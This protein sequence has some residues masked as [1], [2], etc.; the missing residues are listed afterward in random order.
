M[1]KQARRAGPIF[2]S[3]A[4]SRATI[5]DC[6]M[7]SLSTNPRKS[8]WYTVRSGSW[9]VHR[10]VSRS[11]SLVLPPVLET[12]ERAKDTMVE[13]AWEMPLDSLFSVVKKKKRDKTN[14]DASQSVEY[15]FRLTALKVMPAVVLQKRS[16]CIL[17]LPEGC[18]FRTTVSLEHCYIVNNNII[19]E[20][21]AP[22]K[23]RKPDGDSLRWGVDK[24]PGPKK[25]V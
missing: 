6:S 15:S 16:I 5:I 4:C 25:N 1:E 3:P 14:K 23:Q 11:A 12:W 18:I 19:L 21:G 20:W 7:R 17:V 22:A 10:G 8:S 9:N 24:I 2:V 13:L